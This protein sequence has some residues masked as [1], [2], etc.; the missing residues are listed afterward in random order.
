[1]C[2]VKYQKLIRLFLVVHLHLLLNLYML[3]FYQ[4]IL[5]GQ[6]FRGYLEHLHKNN[7]MTIEEM[8]NGSTTVS[9]E[10]QY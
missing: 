3:I 8:E 10:A 6:E 4:C 9:E 7:M 5:I 1:M 2:L